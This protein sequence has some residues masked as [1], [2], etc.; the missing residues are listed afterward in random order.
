V[1][2]F[3]IVDLVTY[4]D[5]VWEVE[6]RY[7]VSVADS[8]FNL[9]TSVLYKHILIVI[10]FISFRELEEIDREQEEAEKILIVLPKK[11]EKCQG[12]KMGI[13]EPYRNKNPKYVL[14]ASYYHQNMYNKVFFMRN[15]YILF[16]VLS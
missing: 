5:L 4:L 9:G 13:D 11:S 12:C 7:I 3:S 15:I 1:R 16:L 8:C 2:N 10:I 6:K 14:K